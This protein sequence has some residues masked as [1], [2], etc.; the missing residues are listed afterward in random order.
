MKNKKV[1]LAMSGGVDSSVAALLLKKQ[2]YEVYGFFM[3][4]SPS[5]KTIWPSSISWKEEEKMVQKICELVG[6][7]ELFVVDCEQGYENKII[8]PMFKDYE[9]GLTPNPDILCNNIG[10]FPGLLK[11][12]KEIK[13][14][15][16]ATGHYA[17][18]KKSKEEFELLAGKDKQKDQS[19]FLVGLN[20][21]ILSK[22]L[23]PV[24]N[25]TKE[26]VRK[27]AKKNKFPNWD[28]HGSRG[29]CYLGKID[30]KKFLHERVKEKIGVVKNPEGEIIGKHPGIMFFTVGERIGE[31]KGFEIDNEYRKKTGNKKLYIAEKKKGNILIVAPEND[32]ALKKKSIRINK[33]KFICGKE[34]GKMKARIR[35]LGELNPGKLK[36]ENGKWVFVFD[37]GVEGIAE[38]Q[39]AVFYKG[40]RV[41]GGGEIRL[42]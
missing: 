34:A 22:C 26:E 36:K 1:L 20:Q 38:G 6:V 29:I 10:K 42:K 37:K 18:I 11:K 17:R 2:D 24:G 19:Y 21:K 12:A 23:F 9:K 25:L 35:H 7:K 15:F 39:F 13:A 32:K 14:D 41:I 5:G 30:M 4:A 3:N 28:K 27:I 16:I 33:I 8:K 40:E 31:K